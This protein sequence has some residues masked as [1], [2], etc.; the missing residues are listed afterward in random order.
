MT[1]RADN[2]VMSPPFAQHDT[3]CG[4]DWANIWSSFFI[5]K[6]L[7]IFPTFYF[8]KFPSVVLLFLPFS[9]SKSHFVFTA[10]FCLY[11]INFAYHEPE[12]ELPLLEVIF[13]AH[14]YQHNVL[15]IIILYIAVAD[16]EEVAGATISHPF[17]WIFKIKKIWIYESWTSTWRL[18][19]LTSY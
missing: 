18:E 17:V 12:F 6:F 16:L 4:G 11:I 13:F 15:L 8:H 19:H 3:P 5:R 9:L 10:A 7:C 1:L 2:C 14:L